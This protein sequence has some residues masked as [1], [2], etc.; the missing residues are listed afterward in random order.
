[1][2]LLYGVLIYIGICFGFT[3]LYYAFGC[4]LNYLRDKF[5]ILPTF[6][7]TKKEEEKIKFDNP[8]APINQQMFEYFSEEEKQYCLSA[9]T[10]AEREHRFLEILATNTNIMCAFFNNM[11]KTPHN[12]TENPK[13]TPK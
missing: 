8:L 11:P 12:N 10:Q 5:D 2:W 3:I 9:P 7:K 1:M 13:N 6:F 4:V